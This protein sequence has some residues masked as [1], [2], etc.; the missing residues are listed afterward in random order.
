[1][2]ETISRAMNLATGGG[3]GLICARAYRNDWRAFVAIADAIFNAIRGE[4]RHC[5]RCAAYERMTERASR[6]A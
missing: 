2:L 3:P 5:R 6:N 1:M 4:R